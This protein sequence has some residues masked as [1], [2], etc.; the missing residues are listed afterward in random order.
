[1]TLYLWLPFF[2]AF[3]VLKGLL[4]VPVGAMGHFYP[5]DNPLQTVEGGVLAGCVQTRKLSV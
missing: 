2:A 4:I 5:G 3:A 1:M